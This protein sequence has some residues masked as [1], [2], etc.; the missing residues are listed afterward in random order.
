MFLTF[1]SVD[2]DD[3]LVYVNPNLVAALMPGRRSIKGGGT[4]IHTAGSHI[5][6]PVIESFEDVLKAVTEAQESMRHG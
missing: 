2:G 4:D 1:T 6:I 3:N 5:P